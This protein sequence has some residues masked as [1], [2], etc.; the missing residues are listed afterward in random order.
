MARVLRRAALKF[1]HDVD[2]PED[3]VQG[4]VS[5]LEDEDEDGLLAP[6]KYEDA[7]FKAFIKIAPDAKANAE[8][9]EIR[10]EGL[11]TM[12]PTR[13]GQAVFGVK[14]YDESWRALLDAWETIRAPFPS[15]QEARDEANKFSS[16]VNWEG[17]FVEREDGNEELEFRFGGYLGPDGQVRLE[18]VSGAVHK[19]EKE[20]RA[21]RKTF[22]SLTDNL[23]VSIKGIRAS[24]TMPVADKEKR[25]LSEFEVETKKLVRDMHRRQVK[26]TEEIDR[27]I[28]ARRLAVQ[29]AITEL[30]EEERI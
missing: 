25:A 23:I 9:T 13:I 26:L 17:G 27:N 2:A 16:V 4:L 11:M 5:Y 18:N 19:L 3:E 20:V 14:S 28:V 7:W 30:R 29:R 15:L 12:L 6:L 8:D 21:R 1:H 22:R 24:G 10:S